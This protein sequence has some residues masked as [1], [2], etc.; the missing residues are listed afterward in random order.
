MEEGGNGGGG[1]GSAP[2]APSG[3]AATAANAQVNLTWSASSGASGYYLKP[4]T[5]SGSESQI[6]ASPATAFTDNAVT[7]GTKY[8]YVV[9]AYNSYGQSANSAEVNA[10]P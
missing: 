7:N 8:F 9:S 4:S 1:G 5:T 10:M 3:L 6:A 2:A